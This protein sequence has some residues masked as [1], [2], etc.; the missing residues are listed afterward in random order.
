MDRS[1]NS[2]AACYKFFAAETIHRDDRRITQQ[3]AKFYAFTFFSTDYRDQTNSCCFVVYHTDSGFV[4]NDTG[5]CCCG[6]IT[7]QCDHIQTNGAYA[8]HRFQ[9]FQCQCTFFTCIDHAM[10]FADRDEC[11]TQAANIGRCHNA[12]FFHVIIQ[13][14]QC[15]C[16]ARGTCFFQTHFLEDFCD[17]IANSRSR[18][19]RQVDAGV[20]CGPSARRCARAGS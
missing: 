9:F 16:C 13:K 8:C 7:G 2:A 15:C 17:T 1:R 12:A 18:S 11:T 5:K 3:T 6:S 4:G 10:V 19:Q 14:S 20:P